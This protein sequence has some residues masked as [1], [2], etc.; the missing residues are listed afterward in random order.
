[1]FIAV[2]DELILTTDATIIDETND[3]FVALPIDSYM[4]GLSMMN[5]FRDLMLTNDS[6]E[7]KAA[8]ETF[9]FNVESWV[10]LV[11]EDPPELR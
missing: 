9:P 11:T 4:I 2:D 8:T 5:I 3:L 10:V 1:M 6:V 7:T